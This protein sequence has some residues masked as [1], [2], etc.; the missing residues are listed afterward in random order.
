MSRYPV[1]IGFALCTVMCSSLLNGCGSNLYQLAPVRGR[2]TCQGKPATG[3]MV[4]FQPIDAPDKTGRP[5]GHSGSASSGT[6]GEDGTFILTSMDGKAGAGA[7]V[8]PHQVLFRPPPTKRPTLPA[9]DRATMSPEEIKAA[10]EVNRRMPVYPPLPCSAN[11]SPSDV[12]VKPGQNEFV[13]TLQ[14]K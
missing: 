4:V 2:V 13:F 12:E 9:D 10:E 14:P 8:G 11:L 5:A 6:V 7:L 3:G 1:R